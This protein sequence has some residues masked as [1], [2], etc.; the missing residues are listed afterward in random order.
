MKMVIFHNYLTWYSNGSELAFK[1][2]LTVNDDELN[3]MFAESGWDKESD[4]NYDDLCERLYDEHYEKMNR[5]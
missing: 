5:Y 3:C 1:D 2:W 4:F